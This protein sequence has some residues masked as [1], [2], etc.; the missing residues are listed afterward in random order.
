MGNTI[1][2]DY[3]R[4][5]C[6]IISDDCKNAKLPNILKE[7]KDRNLDF[8]IIDYSNEMASET[9]EKRLSNQPLG[10]LLIL[11]V[12][13]ELSRR[14]VHI[15]REIHFSINDII[16]ISDSGLSRHVFCGSCHFINENIQARRFNCKKCLNELEVSDHFSAYYQAVLGYPVIKQAGVEHE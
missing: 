11:L 3:N 6:L 7:M 9:L 16:V 10:C 5:R 15:A 4:P 14:I 12:N 1:A 13:P 8:Q 2:I